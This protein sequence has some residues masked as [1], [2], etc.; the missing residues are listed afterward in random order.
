MDEILRFLFFQAHISFSGHEQ[1]FT[2]VKREFSRESRIDM[3][4]DASIIR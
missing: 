4:M 1:I 2:L 3:I